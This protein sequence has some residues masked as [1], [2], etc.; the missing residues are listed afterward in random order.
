MGLSRLNELIKAFVAKAKFHVR[1][2]AL[3][4]FASSTRVYVAL[5]HGWFT[6]LQANSQVMSHKVNSV[7]LW[8]SLTNTTYRKLI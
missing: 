6:S 4:S 1:K 7:E 3:C 2:N 8:I 5:K